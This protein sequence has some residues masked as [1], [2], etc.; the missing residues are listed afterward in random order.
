MTV[1]ALKKN[2]KLTMWRPAL[3]GLGAWV[4]TSLA[5]CPGCAWSEEST[6]IFRCTVQYVSEL[7]LLQGMHVMCSVFAHGC[8]CCDLSAILATCSWRFWSGVDEG[9][10]SI[11]RAC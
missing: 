1:V 7:S 3:L 10:Q 2:F 4:L 6:L 8:C 9:A 11:Q 5:T